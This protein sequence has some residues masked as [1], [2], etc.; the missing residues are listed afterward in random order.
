MT[1]DVVDPSITAQGSMEADPAI[2]PEPVNNTEQ[3]IA[4]ESATQSSDDSIPD[5]SSSTE[6]PADPVQPSSASEVKE[7]QRSIT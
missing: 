5:Q 6:L 1:N 2:Q 3:T 4:G 7:I